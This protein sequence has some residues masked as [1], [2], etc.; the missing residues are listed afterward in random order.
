MERRTLAVIAALTLALALGGCS[1]AAP[2]D[3][4]VPQSA[5]GTGTAAP[6]G[7]AAGSRLANGLY[8][9]DDGTVIALGTL[10][11]RDLEGGFWAV[12][13]GTES[14]GN[15]GTVVAV[16]ANAEKDDPFYVK[17]AGMTVQVIGKRLEGASIRSAGPEIEATSITAITDT[18]GAAE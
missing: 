8:D 4:K 14:E 7:G 3:G 11:W 2:N 15:V 5:P 9:Q 18:P 10:E 17:L 13:G 6:D 12:V 1:T 16:V